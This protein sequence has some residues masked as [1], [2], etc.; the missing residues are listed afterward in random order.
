MLRRYVCLTL[1][2]FIQSARALIYWDAFHLKEAN[3]LSWQWGKPLKQEIEEI[4]RQIEEFKKKLEELEGR[5]AE[6]QKKMEELLT[7][8]KAEGKKLGGIN[9][10]LAIR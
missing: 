10:R 3:F 6:E 2:H 7:K 1:Y 9:L 5:K 4:Q 8:Q